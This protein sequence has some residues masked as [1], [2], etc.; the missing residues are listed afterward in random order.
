MPTASGDKASDEANDNDERELKYGHLAKK[1]EDHRQ[2]HLKK[3]KLDL[4]IWDNGENP[5]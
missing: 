4:I 2:K 5:I 3:R 1:K